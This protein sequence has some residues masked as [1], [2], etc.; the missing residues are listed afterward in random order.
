MSPKLWRS[1]ALAVLP[2]G[3]A[4]GVVAQD[5]AKKSS[6]E[7]LQPYWNQLDLT[8]EQRNQYDR[9][10]R[11]YAPKIDR[12]EAELEALKEKRRKEWHGILTPAQT[13]KLESLQA[14][15][16]KKKAADKDDHTDPAAAPKRGARKPV[17][18]TPEETK[19]ATPTKRKAKDVKDET[20]EETKPTKKKPKKDG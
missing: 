9:V 6:H 19:P 13:R 1:V 10:V 11:E 2:I 3:L 7:R 5:K 18:E 16:N 15:R 4:V 14:S 17:D 12:L 8:D 20:T